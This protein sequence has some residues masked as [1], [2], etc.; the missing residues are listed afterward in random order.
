MTDIDKN[1]GGLTVAVL[2]TMYQQALPYG[3]SLGGKIFDDACNLRHLGEMIDEVIWKSAIPTMTMGF[4]LNFFGGP[5][6]M[7]GIVPDM[8][9]LL[10]S[11]LTMGIAIAFVCNFDVYTKEVQ[12]MIFIGLLG[13]DAMGDVTFV[14]AAK[15]FKTFFQKGAK[16]ILGKIPGKFIIKINQVVGFR[17]ITLFGQRGVINLGNYI[18]VVGGLVG[19]AT[20]GY[21]VNHYGN[22]LK[23]Y[24]LETLKDA[25]F[26]C[27]KRKT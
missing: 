10:L 27:K 20:N 15:N 14:H 25:E 26:T 2:D 13:E 12:I 24:I 19:G 5:W 23:T 22:N 18:P 16:R 6:A 21:T 7:A 4:A 1:S 9:A 11:V 17:F 8:A 3:I